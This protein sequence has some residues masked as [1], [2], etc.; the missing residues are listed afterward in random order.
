MN[1]G[2]V[3][4]KHRLRRDL[5]QQA[6]ADAMFIGRS[7]YAMIEHRGTMKAC[8]IPRLCKVLQITPNDLFQWD[9]DLTPAEMVEQALFNL[10]E[11]ER[12]VRNQQ[13]VDV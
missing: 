9:P 7:T 11:I 1:L 13:K 10:S 4:K 8:Y 3:I 12:F 5:S 2:S 6:V